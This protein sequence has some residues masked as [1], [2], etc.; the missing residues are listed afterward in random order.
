MLQAVLGFFVEW[1]CIEKCYFF[2][3]SPFFNNCAIHEVKPVL[4]KGDMHRFL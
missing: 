4:L 3:V 2:H 1:F